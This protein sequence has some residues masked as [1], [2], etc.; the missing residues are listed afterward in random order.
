LAK[1]GS[2][3][4][5]FDEFLASFLHKHKFTCN[6]N[7]LAKC[8]AEKTFSFPL[9]ILGDI[10][11]GRMERVRASLMLVFLTVVMA[12]ALSLVRSISTEFE[13][14]GAVTSRTEGPDITIRGLHYTDIK[15]PTREVEAFA[16]VALVSRKEK[17]AHLENVRG[18]VRMGDSGTLYFTCPAG[19]ANLEDGSGSAT[20]GVSIVTSGGYSIDSEDFRYD[21]KTKILRSEGRVK[22]TGPELTGWGKGVTIETEPQIIKI[23]EGVEVRITNSAPVK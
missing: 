3:R 7:W 16:T 17:I 22:F 11:H 12:G 2:I 20:G 13:D 4:C 9:I 6:I 21:G 5:H 18:N 23:V 1:Y 19:T 8:R 15:G 10:F 14:I